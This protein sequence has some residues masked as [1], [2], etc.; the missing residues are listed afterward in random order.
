MTNGNFKISNKFDKEVLKAIK[1][2]KLRAS[3]FDVLKKELEEEINNLTNKE[4]ETYRGF[5]NL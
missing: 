5:Y 3:L 1:K 2:R 4:L